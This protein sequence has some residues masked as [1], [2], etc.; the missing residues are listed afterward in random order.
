MKNTKNEYD[1]KDLSPVNALLKNNSFQTSISR[2]LPTNNKSSE[3]ILTLYMNNSNQSINN[4]NKY[5]HI[6]NFKNIGAKNNFS[7]IS[8]LNLPHDSERV[9]RGFT[10]TVLRN[11]NFNP[12][13]KKVCYR[14]IRLKPKRSTEFPSLKLKLTGNKN[15]FRNGKIDIEKPL[16]KIKLE[17]NLKS[18]DNIMNLYREKIDGDIINKE[19]NINNKKVINFKSDQ[20]KFFSK[21]SGEFTIFKKFVNF[22]SD[23][24]KLTLNHYLSQLSN[25]IEIQRNVL[26]IDNINYNY[27][28]SLLFIDNINYNYFESQRKEKTILDKNMNTSYQNI[29]SQPKEK[30]KIILDEQKVHN[31]FDNDTMFKYLN[32]NSEYNTLLN[33]CFDLVFNELKELKE[34]NMELLKANFENDILLNSRNKELK[35]IQK[36]LNSNEAKAFFDFTRKKEDIV[37]KIYIMDLY[38]LNYEMKELILL[39]NRNKDY[40]NKYKELQEKEKSSIKENFYMKAHLTNELEKNEMK[41][42]NEREINIDLNERIMELEDENNKLKDMNENMKLGEIQYDSKIKRLYDI[43]KEKNENL[44]MMKEELDSYYFK[45]YKETKN[46]E[47]TKLILQQYK[48]S[49]KQNTNK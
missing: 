42:Q 12:L 26:F 30:K 16:N 48:K 3:D 8:S 4:L 39:L 35:E 9:Q 37:K 13:V 41:Y 6:L 1:F 21:I 29:I 25:L 45:Y 23:R 24:N 44:R 7:T 11:L 19:F 22:M 32:I 20:I 47:T 49:E 10:N 28:E 38:N 2:D 36:Y 40:Y 34:K 15:F 5:V 31:L 46:H 17:N 27:F 33:K 18:S 43:I 14:T